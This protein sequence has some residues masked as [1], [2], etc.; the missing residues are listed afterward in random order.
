TFF[1][2]VRCGYVPTTFQY[3]CPY[4][5]RFRAVFPMVQ[6]HMN[7]SEM[8][9]DQDIC[10]LSSLSMET[11]HSITH[12][13]SAVDSSQVN[14]GFSIGT[15]TIPKFTSKHKIASNCGH[16]VRLPFSGN[17]ILGLK[18]EPRYPI[19]AA[20]MDKSY[21]A[22]PRYSEYY[23]V[24]AHR[25]KVHF[26]EQASKLLQ[27]ILLLTQASSSLQYNKTI[28]V[29]E[30]N[31]PGAELAQQLHPE[32]PLQLLKGIAQLKVGDFVPNSICKYAVTMF[33]V[34]KTVR[35]YIDVAGY[36][37]VYLKH[38]PG[39][40]GT[41]LYQPKRT[42]TLHVSGEVLKGKSM[43]V[44]AIMDIV[45][46]SCDNL[47]MEVFRPRLPECADLRDIAAALQVI[48]EGGLELDEPHDVDD[49][50]DD[51]KGMRGIGI[52]VLGGTAVIGLL[53]LDD[54][55]RLEF[56][57]LGN[58][59]HFLLPHLYFYQRSLSSNHLQDHDI[60]KNVSEKGSKSLVSIPS[61]STKTVGST[62][63][64]DYPGLWDDLQSRHVAVPLAAWALAS[65][66]SASGSNRSKISEL[67]R[68]GHA[69]MTALVAP[70]RS[71]KWHGALIAQLLMEDKS[72]PVV[73]I[74][75]EWSSSLLA[76]AVQACKA[77]DIPLVRVALSSFFVTIERS[78][79][80]Q[81]AVI[82]K[83]LQLMREITKQT[84]T[85]QNIQE[86]LAKAIELLCTT[87][88][89]L[90]LEESKQWSGI[91][92]RWVSGRYS[93][94][95]TRSSAA[96]VLTHIL[97]DHG[98]NT[99]IIS[100]AWL[101][102]LLSELIGLCKT[103]P[104]KMTNTSSKSR[105]V[106]ASS[107]VQS[108]IIQSAVQSATQLAAIVAYTAERQWVA[109]SDSTQSQP[110]DDLLML[111][112]FS[113]YKN[114]K[115]KDRLPKV[116]VA[117]AALATVKGIKALTELCSENHTYQ[118]RII[119]SGGLF[120]L[121]R[122]M[123]SDD[124]E[125]LAATEAYDASRLLEAQ[126][127]VFTPADKSANI[128][129]NNAST[130]RLPPTA[131]IRKH[132]ARLLTILSLQSE[133]SKVIADDE[134]WCKWLEDCA[135]GKITG[136]SDLK[137][138]SYARATLLHISNTNYSENNHTF[139]SGKAT[140]M[141][142]QRNMCPR[143][144]D[145]VFIINPEASYYKCQSYQNWKMP[146]NSAIDMTNTEYSAEAVDQGIDT[147]EEDPSIQSNIP[148]DAFQEI[149]EEVGPSLDVVFVHGLRG[150]PFKT[151]R[152][153][154]NKSSTTS[155]SGLVEKIDEESGREG[156][157]WPREWLAADLPRTRFLTV[158]YKTNLSQW[159]GAT[160]P[161]EEV[162]LMLLKKLVAAG[163]GDRPVVFVTHS[164]GGL[165][166]KQMLFQAG[167]QNI[168]K[169]VNNTSG[170]VFYSCPHFGSKLADMPWRMGLILRPA[171]SI[172]ELRSGS[173]R[174][175][176]LNHFVRQ[177]HIKSGLQVLSF[178]ET[179][180]TPLVEGYGGWA[181]R[182][183]VVPIE[184]AYPGFGELVVLDGTDHVN[185]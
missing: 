21:R 82:D 43:L 23:Q 142:F 135:N 127:Q 57:F 17:I 101:T 108:Q 139:G 158:K 148:H 140:N 46:T 165:V 159:S 52:K 183:E 125:Q 33:W 16:F 130:V 119:E 155:K 106:K 117:D 109:T 129:E 100:Q 6:R 113:E 66:A 62:E 185:S 2:L 124:Y 147:F 174:L 99:V 53:R 13:Y 77:H 85:D 72:V 170:I 122:F 154:D 38:F 54:F 45:T 80:A 136:C 184:S 88:I 86:V 132:A 1:G 107:V 56:P 31:F 30:Y 78:S 133:T 22:P 39:Y 59:N 169:L 75:V 171:P 91:L 40:L 167:K 47:N 98:P 172:G 71:V 20:S 121:R 60:V 151:W 182:M 32:R 67:D 153:T 12:P 27:Q 24:C 7:G 156:T 89:H 73:D 42:K 141:D 44:A 34:H 25:Q 29:S 111:N 173:P 48:E 5:K 112:A 123:L 65:W 162:S 97:E 41:Y 145:M 10:A 176:E 178:S 126:D 137:L 70:E 81:K 83:G 180:V 150:G 114:P 110:M 160:L 163:I 146:R 26:M 90:S 51:R 104:A 157:C 36:C 3:L 116:D 64:F 166:V 103:T 84:E 105:E 18:T 28:L 61:A 55:S 69:V 35:G 175:E 50:G 87:G 9:K 134:A 95:G 149:Q 14:E 144:E 115:K 102:L 181:F 93:G 19:T 168:T 58:W 118:K 152:M 37:F 164:M 177:L 63:K 68:D 4:L 179:K 79:K 138:R 49:D 120:L 11:L 8:H 131:H 92:L 74:G 161:L 15:Q 96:N 94:E 128:K 143:Y 76:M